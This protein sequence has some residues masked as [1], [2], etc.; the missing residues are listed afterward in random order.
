VPYRKWSEVKR[1]GKLSPE[2]LGQ[3][4]REVRVV[5]QFEFSPPAAGT[6]KSREG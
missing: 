6:R 5:G 4:E 2:R 3:I 1:N